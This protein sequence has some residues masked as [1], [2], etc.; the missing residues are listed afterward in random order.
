MLAGHYSTALLANQKFGKG[1]LLYFLMASQLQDFLWF[2]FHYFGLESTLPSDALNA[3]LSNMTVNMLYSHDLIPQLFWILIVFTI[4]K[5]AFKSTKIGLV[6]AGLLIGHFVLDFFSGHPHHIF[7]ADTHAVGLG[8]YATNVY[9]AIAIEAVFS[10]VALWYFFKEE[11]K[12]GRQRTAKNK[13]S[14]IGVFVFGILFMLSIATTSF[15]ELLGIPELDLGLNTNV[16]TLILTY[17]GMLLFLNHFVPQF[18]VD[19]NSQR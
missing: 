2:I 8:L 6:G 16:P 19:K 15:R 4:G 17:V 7:G 11:G 1:T 10:T 3:T 12:N 18:K 14:I 5:L 13:A 9:L